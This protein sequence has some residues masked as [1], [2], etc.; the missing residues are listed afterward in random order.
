[1]NQRNEQ[2]DGALNVILDND[3][4][5]RGTCLY[6][7]VCD[8]LGSDSS[9]EDYENSK[10]YIKFN[11]GEKK[12][13]AL[14][15]KSITYLGNPHPIFKKRIQ[16]PFW[17]IEFFRTYNEV[18][19]IRF[20]GVYHYQGLVIFSDFDK[21]KYVERNVNN[22]SAHVYTND[23]FQA[24]C[25]G[26]FT[27]VDQN[28]NIIHTISSRCFKDY[29]KGKLPTQFNERQRIFEV[30]KDSIFGLLMKEFG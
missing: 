20:I 21:T 15:V 4:P 25:Y 18:Y 1:M 22:S 10:S 17:W 13:I 26:T 23:L 28:D 24:I 16:I 30:F 7:T 6:R 2:V 14:L 11:S 5:L 29:L 12:P 19:D 27:K 3:Q 8:I 9:I